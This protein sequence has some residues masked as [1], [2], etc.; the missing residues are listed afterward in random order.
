MNVM[1]PGEILAAVM[2]CGESKLDLLVYATE[3]R[4]YHPRVIG[5]AINYGQS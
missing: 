2:T 5:V 3:R 4:E 1:S